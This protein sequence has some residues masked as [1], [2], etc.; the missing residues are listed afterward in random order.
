M[1]ALAFEVVAVGVSLK[2]HY[3]PFCTYPFTSPIQIYANHLILPSVH[4]PIALKATIVSHVIV[5]VLVEDHDLD[6]GFSLPG[7]DGARR[8]AARN[9]EVRHDVWRLVAGGPL[10]SQ[11]WE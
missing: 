6:A 10:R 3:Q 1:L 8:R 11:P 7:E 9:A 5:V 2:A 4:H